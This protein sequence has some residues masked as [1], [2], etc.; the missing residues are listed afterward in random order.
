MNNDNNNINN[1]IDHTLLKSNATVEDIERLCNEAKEYQF[2]SVCVNPYYVE[3]AKHYLQGT[4]I[5]VAC[6]VGFPLGANLTEIKV[7]EAKRAKED[8]ADEIDMV[9]NI[10]AFKAKNYDYVL[11]EINAVCS[12]V[13][14][15]VKVI[16]ETSELVGE[17]LKT[18]CDIFNK[19]NAQFIK[20]STGFTSSGA[21]VEDVKF[22]RKHTLKTKQVKASGGIRDLQTAKQMLKAGAERLGLSS[23]VKIALEQL[24]GA[25][26]QN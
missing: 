25:N 23:G 14:I 20:T 19:S 24:E 11:N 26:R 3:L 15:P 22:I 16:I 4:S 6:V 7:L 21:N 1:K 8:G 10:G 17:E 13:G 5:K 18:A 2:Y 9:M 12:A